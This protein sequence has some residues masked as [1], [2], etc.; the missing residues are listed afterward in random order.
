ML[1]KLNQF[2]GSKFHYDLALKFYAHNVK[3]R[4]QR[5]VAIVSLW[6]MHDL[7]IALK[8]EPKKDIVAK[9]LK[10]LD[11]QYGIKR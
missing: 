8:F 7:E 6:K 5:A 2:E 9:E 3:A 10:K 11:G 4:Y 1:V